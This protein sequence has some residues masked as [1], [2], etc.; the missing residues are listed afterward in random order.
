MNSKDWNVNSM[1]DN[2][3]IQSW[4]SSQIGHNESGV[5]SNED[6]D[7]PDASQKEEDALKH[8]VTYNISKGKSYLVKSA[9]VMTQSVMICSLKWAFS[10]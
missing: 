7:K 3:A 8:P 2:E 6:M 10:F 4:N 5:G 1:E 9:V